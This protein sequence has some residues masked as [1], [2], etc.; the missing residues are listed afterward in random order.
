[1]KAI[2]DHLFEQALARRTETDPLDRLTGALRD[3]NFRPET[4]ELRRYQGHLRRQRRRALET[5]SLLAKMQNDKTNLDFN[6]AKPI[7]R[8]EPNL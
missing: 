7:N 5:L 6:K 8:L 2:E 1:M 3:L 4:L